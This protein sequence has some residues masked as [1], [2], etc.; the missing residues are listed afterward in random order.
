[1][2]VNI[3]VLILLLNITVASFVCA[4]EENLSLVI[5]D[6][7]RIMQEQYKSNQKPNILDKFNRILHLPIIAQKEGDKTIKL[8]MSNITQGDYYDLFNVSKKKYKHTQD[9]II[10][11]FVQLP[12]ELQQNVIEKMFKGNQKA[13]EV[14]VKTNFM[15]SF[16]LFHK[17]KDIRYYPGEL[18]LNQ[19]AIKIVLS[20]TEYEDRYEY[21]YKNIKVNSVDSDDSV[22]HSLD[23]ACQGAC[24]G[25][26]GAICGVT[27][28]MSIGVC[29]IVPLWSVF[30]PWPIG[31]ALGGCI[32]GSC[33]TKRDCD[34][35]EKSESDTQ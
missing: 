23:P 3:R 1:M 11:N 26:F 21:K 35:C 10:W 8:A 12:V 7:V 19:L 32:G 15:Y 9:S 29:G 22:C 33:Y 4:G 5:N 34:N 30:V 24:V 27:M 18:F 31:A 16:E 2:Y 14:F 13:S 17:I 6:S 25:L 28:P 20:T